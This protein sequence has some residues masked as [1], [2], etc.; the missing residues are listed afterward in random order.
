M[1]EVWRLVS[2]GLLLF[3]VLVSVQAKNECLKV[4]RELS[5]DYDTF[6]PLL[7]INVRTYN[8]QSPN[9]DPKIRT[10]V[11]H[12][13]AFFAWLVLYGFEDPLV[14]D[15][16]NIQKIM[17]Y[18]CVY[19]DY[20]AQYHIKDHKYNFANLKIQLTNNDDN[21][22]ALVVVGRDISQHYFVIQKTTV[23]EKEIS[24][25][26]ARLFQ[27]WVNLFNINDWIESKKFNGHALVESAR[28]IYGGGKLVPLDQ[29]F[30]DLEAYE[31]GAIEQEKDNDPWG[32]VCNEEKPACLAHKRLFG[33]IPDYKTGSMLPMHYVVRSWNNDDC[34]NNKETLLGFV[35][36]WKQMLEDVKPVMKQ[37][38]LD[39]VSKSMADLKRQ[40]KDLKE[41]LK[42]LKKKKNTL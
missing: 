1:S 5:Q 2:L 30:T 38:R 9:D 11:C 40:K 13:N 29:L 21:M 10:T 23:I 17:E 36:N 18:G 42:G 34:T 7:Q 33:Q 6:I 35:Q 16:C 25:H 22:A 12:K 14:T 37:E 19:T 28:Q 41:D 26:K 24:V 3:G 15:G 32:C 4:M 39:E 27:G 31:K 20:L 8:D